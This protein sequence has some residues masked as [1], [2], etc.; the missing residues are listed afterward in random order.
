MDICNTD[1][2]VNGASALNCIHAGSGTNQQF[3]VSEYNSGTMPNFSIGRLN[4]DTGVFT[5]SITQI[6]ADG[7]LRLPLIASDTGVTDS[8][9]CQRTADHQLFSGSGT[10]GICLGTSSARF[11][12]DIAPLDAGLEQIMNL[13]AVRYKLNEDHGDPNKTLYGFTAEQGS[14]ALPMLT[15]V[16]AEGNPNTFDY[17]GVVPV[18]VKAVQEQQKA[19]QEQ[20]KE[21]EHLQSQLAQSL[22]RER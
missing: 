5:A 2:I 22:P 18:L 15:G 20:Q 1:I 13:E 21:I 3:G 8:T 12:H 6:G 17:L 11:K 9:V 16:D 7:T 4:G 19:M 14:R 10:A